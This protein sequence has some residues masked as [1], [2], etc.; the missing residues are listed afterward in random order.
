M[1]AILQFQLKHS[2][3]RYVLGSTSV[4]LLVIGWFCGY[5]FNLTA[6]EG[7][8]LNS[9]YTI[10]FM[11]A[12][13]SL[14]MIF[15]AILFALEI[16]FKEWDTKFD[17]MLFSYPVSLKTYL[18][19][20]FSGFT[21]KTFV[22]FSILI[23]GFVIGQ[24]IRTG[25]EMQLGFS[26][27]SYLYPFLIFGVLNCLF[28]CSVLFMIAY[29]TRKKLLVVIGGLLLYVLYMVL[30]VFSNSPF[31]AGSI[32]Q[33]IEVQQLS[34][35]LDPFGTSAYFFEA[36]DLSVTEKNQFIVP[37]KGFLA[38][39]RIVYV[40]LSMLF[41]V[42]SYRF[43]VF[44][45]A[46][47]KKELK[48]KQRNVKVA[49]VKLTNVKI[50]ALDFGFKSELNAIISFAK[51]D[52]IYLFK[53]VTIVAVSMLLVFFVGMEMYSDIDK[54][55]RL[56]DYYASS[57][58]LATSIAQSF[59]LLGGFILVYFINDMYWRSSSANFYLIE[60]SAFFSKAKLKGHLM[61][62]A[63]LLVF[64][65]TLLI[66][67][68]IVFQIGYGYSQ[69]DWLAY[70]GVIIFNTF[71]LFLFGTLLLLINRIINSKYVALGVSILAVVV[72]TTP[73]IKMLLPYPLLHVFSGFKGVF[74]DLN[75][76]GAYLSAFSN[77]SLFGICL[78]GLLWIFNSYLK[79]KQWTK[80][81]SFI[82]IVFLGLSVFT[83]FNFMKGYAP[84][85]EDVQL[86]EAVNYEKNYRHYE[87]ISQPT[88]T[89]VDTKIDL[90]PSENTY[91]IQGKYGL[92]NLSDESI[93]KILLNFHADLKLE[94]ATL[95]IHNEEFSINELV[96]EIE[97]DKP[98]LAN[99]TA[100]LEFNLSYK[101]Y[102]VNGHQSFNAIVQNGSFMRISDY[103][104]SL[105]YQSDKEIEDEQKREAYE[106][107]NPTRLKTLE[108][109]EVFKNDFINLDMV[110]STESH[111][112]PMGIGDVVKTW[113]ENDRA[114]TQYK[115]HGIPFRFAVASA[116]YQKQSIKH[117]NIE[118]E[119]LYHD[120][121]F[122]NVDRLLKNAELSLDYCIDNFNAYP[123]EKISFVEVSSFTSGF[124]AT[125][126]PATIFM[127]ENMI[128]HANIDSDP[129]KDVI[130][131][132]AGHELAHIWW[133][134]SQ[135]NP[136][137]REGASM[138]TE[139]LAMYTEMMIYKKLYGKERMMERVQIHQQIYDNEKGLY[140]NPPLYK[141][142][143]GAT[144]IAYSKGAI[145]MVELSELIG[146]DKV[147]Q[148]LRSFL[149]N[150]KYPKKPTS[151]D[152]LEEF[153]R[154]L[155]NDVLKSEVDQL[156]K[157]DNRE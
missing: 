126:Y 109:P 62:L 81:K 8:Y 25:S 30:L 156:F 111:Q 51:V 72:F 101:W 67:L 152:L 68:A 45:K 48:R 146:E 24:N 121:H 38:I 140:G 94:N 10:G 118:I 11:M 65:T 52:L 136:D 69:I 91:T 61:S 83:G 124:A 138:L 46:T 28:V 134:N 54:G 150:N 122:E 149:A 116:T 29:T 47:S 37:L 49:I 23:I 74:S 9:P 12:L 55:I 59:H 123:F 92:Q 80:I 43:Y 82:V 145:A 2:G 87:N 117:R 19:G 14:S 137:E 17:I 129:S 141:V 114:F 93:N 79:S 104:P 130:N 107:G 102:A 135:I 64:L 108:A 42:I 110:V 75:G 57:G 34:S 50:P 139:S 35:L 32:P 86:I 115:A 85:N 71:P 60:D 100:I 70:L 144:H 7:I 148:A 157:G 143:Y 44:N 31:M 1:N 105:G 98:L 41:L 58:L 90:Y 151:L 66:V 4:I 16:L 147:N 133:G 78:L 88:I 89:D 26:L 128:F 22:S 5:K 39:N 106:L 56:P 6:G 73:L 120:K 40:V 153:Y 20:K 3:N 132:L 76:Y 127:T 84:K 95:Q 33:S 18:V 119:V 142:P 53:S 97:L 36:R 112:T 15:L 103:Y 21:L 154:V 13:L 63:V 96:S 27:W 113:S 125:A 99:D 155:P 131:E 77:R